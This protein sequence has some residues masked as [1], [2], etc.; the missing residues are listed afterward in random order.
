MDL[1]ELS[2]GDL[3]FHRPCGGSTNQ[4]GE[5]ESCV[6]IARISGHSEAFRPA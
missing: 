3:A 6:E 5:G 4:D 1:Y 2:L